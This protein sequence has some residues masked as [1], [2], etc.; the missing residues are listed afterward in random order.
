MMLTLSKAIHYILLAGDGKKIRNY[1]MLS[2]LEIGY[3]QIK[4]VGVCFF[5]PTFAVLSH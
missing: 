2:H 1:V 4:S 5:P 3:L